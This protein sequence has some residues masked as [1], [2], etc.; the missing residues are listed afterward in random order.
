M[1]VLPPLDE[2]DG[3]LLDEEQ[4][5]QWGEIVDRG[6]PQ[7]GV[8]TWWEVLAWRVFNIHPVP[9]G[10]ALLPSMKGTRFKDDTGEYVIIWQS[11]IQAI[12]I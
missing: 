12:K 3:I 10:T 2:V 7:G 6:A 11:D 5:S 8:F 1:R 4:K 9:K